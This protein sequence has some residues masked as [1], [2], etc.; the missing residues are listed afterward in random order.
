MDLGIRIAFANVGNINNPQAKILYIGYD[1][2]QR[3]D[4][5]IRV[6]LFI[7]LFKIF[8]SDIS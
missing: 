7:L 8:Y 4:I 2:T 5:Y 6:I 3:T 1:W